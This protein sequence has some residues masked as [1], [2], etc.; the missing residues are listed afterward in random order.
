MYRLCK[1]WRTWQNC[2]RHFWRSQKMDMFFL[3]AHISVVETWRLGWNIVAWFQVSKH[4]W[5]HC[6]ILHPTFLSERYGRSFAIIQLSSF[7]FLT[8][9]KISFPAFFCQMCLAAPSFFFFCTFIHLSLSFLIFVSQMSLNHLLSLWHLS[10]ESTY[11]YQVGSAGWGRVSL[12]S[13]PH[14]LMLWIKPGGVRM[15][16]CHRESVSWLGVPWNFI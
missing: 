15:I 1:I 2:W 5:E 6:D 13:N 7:E 8:Y 12:T 16:S 10:L 3:V 9:A 14:Q 4:V 11:L